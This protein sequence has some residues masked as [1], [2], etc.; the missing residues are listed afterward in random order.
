MSKNTQQSTSSSIL[1]LE[2]DELEN[3]LEAATR[4]ALLSSEKL[5]ETDFHEKRFR[6]EKA[7]FG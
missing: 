1:D 2:L 6:L 4:K 5:S 7:F 3:E